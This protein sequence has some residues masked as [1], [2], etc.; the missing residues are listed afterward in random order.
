MRIE[1][2]VEIA[3]RE[4]LFAQIDHIFFESS[5][6]KTFASEA[7]RQAFRT[8]WLGRY[9]EHYPEWA[10]VARTSDDEVAGYLVGSIVDPAKTPLFSDIGYFK[11]FAAL[12][13]RYPAQLH[14]NLAPERRGLGIGSRLM[15]AF[16][17]DLARAVVPG[18][19][20]VTSRGVRNVSYYAANGFEEAGSTMWNGRELVFLGRKLNGG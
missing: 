17:T 7:E 14:V 11:D 20:V 8:R 10:Y 13:A 1:R 12:T 6:T 5:N 19:H 18:V 2:W 16:A 9:L 15:S 3:D 4:R